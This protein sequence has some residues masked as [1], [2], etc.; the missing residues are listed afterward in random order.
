MPEY[1]DAAFT[2]GVSPLTAEQDV[3]LTGAWQIQRVTAGNYASDADAAFL[4]AV[5]QAAAAGTGGFDRGVLDKEWAPVMVPANQTRLLIPGVKR[6]LGLWFGYLTTPVY[7]GTG[8]FPH[9]T[10]LMGTAMGLYDGG[11]HLTVRRWAG[12]GGALGCVGW[13]PKGQLHMQGCSW[14]R[15]ICLQLTAGPAARRANA[16]GCW[17]LP[18]AL[19]PT[20]ATEPPSTLPACACLQFVRSSDAN[21]GYAVVRNSTD[22]PLMHV[23]FLEGLEVGCPGCYK[24][25]TADT[26]R[27]LRRSTLAGVPHKLLGFFTCPLCNGL[28][29]LRCC[30]ATVHYD[31]PAA[32]PPLQRLGPACCGSPR[33]PPITAACCPALCPAQLPRKA[34]MPA[35]VPCQPR[36]PAR[37]TLASL[38]AALDH[39]FLA[40]LDGVAPQLPRQR[41]AHGRLRGGGGGQAYA[42]NRA[43]APASAACPPVCHLLGTAVSG[44]PQAWSHRR[45]PPRLLRTCTS[46]AVSVARLFMRVRLPASWASCSNTSTMQSCITCSEEK[47]GERGAYRAKGGRVRGGAL[48]QLRRSRCFQQRRQQLLLRR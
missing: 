28:M 37:T 14:H 22:G 44:Q 42:F 41:Q 47:G 31:T 2:D 8:H 39:R 32:C 9:V 26:A 1:F 18:W 24:L 17:R 35:A 20:P 15:Q 45:G 36:L 34:C 12:P 23:L 25:C 48:V 10:Q 30:A 46:R 4:K 16:R 43:R 38:L 13:K 19:A 3:L 29:H 33:P 21:T 27:Q 7:N 6:Q 11:I 40:L 5:E